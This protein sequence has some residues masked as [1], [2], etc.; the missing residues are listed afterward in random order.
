MK[1]KLLLV[2]TNFINEFGN[3]GQ[4][5]AREIVSILNEEFDVYILSLEHVD[6]NSVITNYNNIP[7]LKLNTRINSKFKKLFLKIYNLLLFKPKFNNEIIYNQDDYDKIQEFTKTNQ[8]E[9]S[10]LVYNYIYTFLVADKLE[11]MLNLTK[12]NKK[13]YVAQNV[14]YELIDFKTISSSYNSK[15]L[16]KYEID[17]LN[18]YHTIALTDKDYNK[19]VTLKGN[20]D[21]LILINPIMKVRQNPRNIKLNQILI[22]TN[23]GWWPNINSIKW[24]FN[25]VYPLINQDYSIIITGKDKDGILQSLDNEH[26]NVI[27]KGFVTDAELQYLYNTVEFIINPTIEGGGFQVKMLEALANSVPVISTDYS[28]HLK[29]IVVSSDSNDGI[30]ELINKKKYNTNTKLDYLNYYNYNKELLFKTLKQ[31]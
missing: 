15:I 3:G 30:A 2:T 14:E 16:K 6:T 21:N 8:L 20:N 26:N 5:L 9:S 19:F 1:Q 31:S 22:T 13:F 11:K 28:N 18:N 27:Y 23:L 10:I 29:S 25:S 12:K 4:I 24:F 7:L 17:I